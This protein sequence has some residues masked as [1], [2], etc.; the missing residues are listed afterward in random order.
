MQPINKISISDSRTNDIEPKNKKKKGLGS[1]A[2]TFYPLPSP[3]IKFQGLEKPSMLLLGP[4]LSLLGDGIRLS[5]L[6][7]QHTHDQHKP[8]TPC[9][10][11][12]RKLN[13]HTYN[14]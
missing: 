2:K 8:L 3:S 6:T 11:W 10:L 5:C 12:G 14:R 9:I 4:S 1:K 13:D 7:S